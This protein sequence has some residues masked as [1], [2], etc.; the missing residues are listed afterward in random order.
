MKKIVALLSAVMMLFTQLSV[1]A[2]ILFSD[3]VENPNLHYPVDPTTI[4]VNGTLIVEFEDMTDYDKTIVKV[5]AV[6]GASGGK[7]LNIE[8]PDHNLNDADNA[9]MNTMGTPDIKYVANFDTYGAYNVWVRV[10]A[11]GYWRYSLDGGTT[12]KMTYGTADPE[13]PEFSW[14]RLDILE[15]RNRNAVYRSKGDKMEI[16]FEHRYKSGTFDKLIL[17]TDLA[18]IPSGAN[19]VPTGDTSHIHPI[20]EFKPIEGHPR[21]YIAAKDV[22]R[23]R[24]NAN[25]PEMASQL[26]NI[27]DQA[28][29]PITSDMGSGGSNGTTPVRLRGRAMAY[30][31]GLV[32]D[33]H[34]RETI[35][36][37]K[38]YL[39]TATY[40][41]MAGDI[42]RQVGEE[43][44]SAA[45]VYDWLY[46]LL[47]EEEK[48]FFVA[49]LKKLCTWKEIAYPPAS[50]NFV[51]GHSGEREI[52]QDMLAVGV[53][54]YDE[55]PEVWNVTA[56]AY[57]KMVP[58][59]KLFNASGN[60]PSGAD[61]YAWRFECEL[62][63]EMILGAMDIPTEYRFSEGAADVPL[64]AI[65]GRRPDGARFREGDET[66]PRKYY[67]YSLA[68]SGAIV[69]MVA[70]L[71]PESEHNALLYGE[72][73]MNSAITNT[74]EPFYTLLL[75]DKD[76]PNKPDLGQN[77]PLTYRSTYP[78]TQVYTRTSWQKGIDAPT[79]MAFMQGRE[80]V[81]DI[82]ASPDLG[83]F[84]I[85]YKGILANDSHGPRDKAGWI[86]AMDENWARR[87]ISQNLVTVKDP[88]E[89]FF[90]NY[91]LYE[92]AWQV[93][94][95]DGGQDYNY[96][97]DTVKYNTYEEMLERKQLAYTEGFYAGPNN[98]TPEF[99][100]LQTDITAAYAG[101]RVNAETGVLMQD[102]IGFEN[103]FGTEIPAS[104]II[105]AVGFDPRVDERQFRYEWDKKYPIVPKVSD[106][107]RSMV[108]IDLFNDDYPAAFV[109]FDKV[110]ST[111]A[112]FEKNWL[113]HMLEEP[114]VDGNTTIVT[115]K[116]FGYNGKMVVKT[117]LPA[118]PDIEIIGG[119][120]KSTY[121]DGQNF[122]DIVDGQNEDGGW[123]IEVSP[124]VPSEKDV[125]LHAMYVTDY[126]RNLPEL[127]MYKEEEGNYVGVT[128]MDRVVM[129]AKDAVDT[130][131]TFTLNIR[132]NN[133]GGD[134]S[135]M[136][137]DVTPGVW[138]VVGP[139]KTQYVEVTEEQCALY[140]KGAPGKYTIKKEEGKVA[141]IIEYPRTEKPLI[142]DYQI[143]GSDGLFLNQKSPTKLINDVPYLAAVDYLPHY[144]AEVIE[145]ADGG[146]TVKM[147]EMK[148]AILWPDTTRA[149][150]NGKE[151]TIANEPKL[152]DGKIYINPI[153]IQGVFNCN[154]TYNPLGLLMKITVLDD[155]EK[156]FKAT[157]TKFDDI[158][159]PVEAVASSDDGNVVEGMLDYNLATRWTGNGRD[160]WFT[161]DLGGVYDIDYLLMAFYNGASRATIFEIE[162]SADGENWREVFR[163]Q[164]SGTSNE[165]EKITLNGADGIRHIRYRGHGNTSNAYNSITECIVVK[166]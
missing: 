19:P 47:T 77:E 16:L 149:I 58:S 96:I 163:G 54:I 64:R 153:D 53:A 94:V 121:V 105:D 39:E 41:L 127:P 148:S 162:V 25:Q 5:K 7:V 138:T 3:T 133:N 14:V 140:F 152:I 150:I 91:Y 106:N 28:R 43:M 142:G 165:F 151:T 117:M 52:F 45:V 128:V 63:S 103:K 93:L 57:Q 129:F 101:K 17:T 23:L 89:I 34:A 102:D 157:N 48:E 24:E 1:S 33:A 26:Q 59:R 10:A 27:K 119:E 85:Y 114:T 113:L 99:T 146:I 49:Q 160:E 15:A 159:V 104:T 71:Y 20:P 76:N 139:D 83:Q 90:D 30:L 156:L 35:E 136:V 67:T 97:L 21:L 18:F 107:N 74:K 9:W 126:D 32:D 46:H 122:G 60:H 144:G 22:E 109:V 37:C 145:N 75:W 88:D 112:T 124:S 2:E 6:D 132:D 155:I 12:W 40:N 141:D 115:R 161:Y 86:T 131:G 118:N 92:R 65:Y 50:T 42:T 36:H 29:W 143:Y 62:M 108:F 130:D 154:I 79:A 80:T 8:A 73:L 84:Q 135:V 166:K 123:R 110:D 95:N 38:K 111:N 137:A 44:E 120:G 69:N 70:N 56:G 164:S 100:Y 51:F 66:E 116:D 82:H 78:L 13:T 72:Y 4:P 61:Y 68:R 134:M 81:T 31:L 87:S 158:I 125:F 55:D 98:I 11:G 147:G